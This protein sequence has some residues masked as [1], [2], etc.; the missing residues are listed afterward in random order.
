MDGAIYEAVKTATVAVALLHP[1]RPGSKNRPFTIVGSGFCI[2]NDG[3]IVTCEHVFRAFVDPQD[4][5]AV[6]ADSSGTRHELRGARPHAIFYARQT[7]GHNM[8]A[9]L[10]PI[11]NA[12]TKTDFDLALLKLASHSAFPGGFPTLGI[13]KYE[14][15]HEMH[16][17][18]TCGFP[19]GEALEEQIGT[20]TSSF[21]RGIISSVIPLQGVP[22]EHLRGFQLDLTATNGNSGGPVFLAATGEVFGVLQGGVIHPGTGHAVQ[23]L[24]KAEPIYP[25]FSNGLVDRLLATRS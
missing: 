12:V 1:D 2:H 14:T 22:Q 5:E 4:Y 10:V 6:T 17:V 25:I 16:E 9:F 7:V 19:L 20:V 18:A 13:A 15:I 23:G 24:T 11:V 21:T 3:L 8:I